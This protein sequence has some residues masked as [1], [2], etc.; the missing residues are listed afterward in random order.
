MSGIAVSL[1]VFATYSLIVS[2]HPLVEN[3]RDI[4]QIEACRRPFIHRLHGPSQDKPVGSRGSLYAQIGAVA[5][6][7]LTWHDLHTTFS[8]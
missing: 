1:A 4:L 2:R 5:G 6:I 7:I 8:E 3:H